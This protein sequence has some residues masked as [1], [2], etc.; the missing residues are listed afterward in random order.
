MKRNLQLTDGGLETTLIYKENI[1]L[2]H[3]A[4]F[5]LLLNPE[6]M[7]VLRNYYKKYIVLAKEKG[8]PFM[9][10]T[11]TWR[12]NHDWGF[13][14]GYK[15]QELA[16]INRKSVNFLRHLNESLGSD[17][18]NTIS[19]CVGPRFDAYRPNLKMTAL[20][21]EAYHD[22]QI[23]AFALA[24]ADQISAMTFTN[25]NEALGVVRAS[26]KYS[27]NI[28][29]SFTVETNGLLPSGESMELAVKRIDEATNAYP[30]YY[31][32]N[33]AHPTH[34]GDIFQSSIAHRIGGLRANASSMSHDDLDNCGAIQEGDHQELASHYAQLL[35]NNPNLN[36]I[37]GCCGTGVK[38]LNAICNLIGV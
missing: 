27:M 29:V 31:M 34:F 26:T 36:L 1:P 6:H 28:V 15:S 16:A 32:L 18:F 30:S 37:G 21:A 38:H 20:E 7:N 35:H 24:D 5:E 10:E 23:K 14:L 22:E 4:A 19:G 13:R 3:F 8:L 33:C 11:P 12:A 9:L 17:K 2:R 25:S